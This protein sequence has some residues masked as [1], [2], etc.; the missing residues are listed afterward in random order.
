[1]RAGGLRISGRLQEYNS[2]D[3]VL[4]R[5]PAQ[6]LAT[7]GFQGPHGATGQWAETALTKASL[8]AP[9]LL[10]VEVANVLRRAS[11]TQE[12]SVEVASLAHHDMPDLHVEL[13]PA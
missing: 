4:A 1:M 13:F 9:A 6:R 10:Q 2:K 11:Q 5:V 7:K 3:D 12:I 8:F